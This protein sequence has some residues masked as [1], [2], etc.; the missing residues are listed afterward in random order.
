MSFSHKSIP[1]LKV[2][3]QAQ[4][5]KFQHDN[6]TML[7]GILKMRKIMITFFA[8]LA[9]VI[10]F[11]PNQAIA[12]LGVSSDSQ[13]MSG[14]FFKKSSSVEK[15]ARRRGS[16]R[17]GH[18]STRRSSASSYQQHASKHVQRGAGYAKSRGYGGGH[19]G[20][21]SHQSK[22][23]MLGGFLKKGIGPAQQVA[24]SPQAQQMARGAGQAAFGAASSVVQ[25]KTGYDLQGAARGAGR[26]AARAQ[27]SAQCYDLGSCVQVI[28]GLVEEMTPY[29]DDECN[30]CPACANEK[31]DICEQAAIYMGEEYTPC[32]CDDEEQGYDDE[33]EEDEGQDDEEDYGDEGDEDEEPV[34]T[35]ES[36]EEDAAW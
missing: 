31:G 35:G 17:G 21:A 34:G 2:R 14:A 16:G 18:S 10:F 11:Q 8:I 9:G 26:I 3:S 30:D 29:A 1:Q 24:S 7:T 36:D 22:S 13:N 33:S 12:L 15:A 23:S 32:E 5:Q 19:G 6:Q 4:H 27:R 25:Q 20:G 28:G